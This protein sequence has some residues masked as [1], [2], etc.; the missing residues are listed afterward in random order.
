MSTPTDQAKAV[1]KA[2]FFAL[3]GSLDLDTPTINEIG[4]NGINSM[5]QVGLGSQIIP[6]NDQD[7]I[8]VGGNFE[9]NFS[10]LVVMQN[11]NSI[12]GNIVYKKKKKGSISSSLWRTLPCFECC[13]E[14][15]RH[16]RQF[17]RS[18]LGL[19]SSS[20]RCSCRHCRV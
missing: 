19:A 4:H 13:G 12:K 14:L 5:V 2:A 16:Q 6:N 7:I 1:E 10:G 17:T 3:L 15:R 20:R 9:N 18:L 11:S 8:L